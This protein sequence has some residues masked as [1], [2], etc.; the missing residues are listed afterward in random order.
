MRLSERKLAIFTGLFFAAAMTNISMNGDRIVANLAKMAE[1]PGDVAL[2]SSGGDREPVSR[3]PA[4]NGL[5]LREL[6]PVPI[7]PFGADRAGDAP[8]VRVAEAR[9]QIATDARPQPIPP[10]TAPAPPVLAQPGARLADRLDALDT[11]DARPPSDSDLDLSP[12]GLSC[13][14]QLSARVVPGALA[15]VMLDAPCHREQ[16]VEFRHAGLVFALRTSRLGLVTARVPVLTPDAEIL[17]VLP[18]G[19]TARITL[20]VPEAASVERVAVQW[21]GPAELVLHALEFGARDGEAGHVWPGAPRSP[22]EALR[23]GGGFIVSLGDGALDAAARAEIYTLPRTPE[24][25]SGT[26][27]LVLEATGGVSA[28]STEVTASALRREAGGQADPSRLELRFELPPCGEPGQT[29]LLKN[30]VG[31]LKIAER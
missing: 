12:Y 25:R 8:P 14:P 19:R 15:E 16:R 1:R 18:N 27:R 5:V 22:E 23:A 7:A 4:R 26:V 11:Q 21:R 17:A 28:C 2:T 29:L 30:V 9:P 31:D 24:T 13:A 20:A 6:Q 3:E 10:E